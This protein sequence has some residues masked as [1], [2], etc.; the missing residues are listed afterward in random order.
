VVENLEGYFPASKGEL[1]AQELK[2]EKLQST[3]DALL[4]I[5]NALTP[6]SLKI[7]A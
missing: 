7:L 1:R 6:V 3:V 5:V 4:N 2:Y